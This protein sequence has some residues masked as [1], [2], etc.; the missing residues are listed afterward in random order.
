MKR[1]A[2]ILLATAAIGACQRNN[3]TPVAAADTLPKG[4][5]MDSAPR[6]VETLFVAQVPPPAPKR[7]RPAPPAPA[8]AP[9]P[10]NPRRDRPEPAPDRGPRFLDAGTD[11]QTTLI[12]SIHS[13]YNGPGDPI[14]ASVTEDVS[15]GGRVVIPA[16]SIVTF[17]I[18]AIGPATSR[19]EKGT[20]DI[21]AES[22][23]INGRT[24]RIHGAANDYDFTMRARAVNA[25]DVATAAGGAGIGAL[26]G[27]VIGGKTGTIVGAIGG[28]AA[29]TAVAAKNADRDI[30]VHANTPMKLSLLEAFER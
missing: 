11:I 26:L 21:T 28:A 23:A 24:Y 16:G 6:V 9:A 5:P 4:A 1:L 20:L 17:R 22:I 13:G 27:H 3:P 10:A 12:D 19:G 15:D 2:T 14:R 18:N 8:P 7:P 29:G 30:I 25:G